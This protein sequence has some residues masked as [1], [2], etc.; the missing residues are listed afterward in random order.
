[1]PTLKQDICQNSEIGVPTDLYAAEMALEDP[2]V[3]DAAAS[4]LKEMANAGRRASQ[5][6]RAKRGR[7]TPG[8]SHLANPLR[9]VALGHRAVPARTVQVFI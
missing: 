4:E 5:D 9:A 2:Y 7:L 3:Y 8:E 6:H 1:V